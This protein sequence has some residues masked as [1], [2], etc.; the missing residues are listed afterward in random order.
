M[1]GREPA[2]APLRTIELLNKLFLHH[3]FFT[4]TVIMA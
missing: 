2:D 3:N 4:S 1:S